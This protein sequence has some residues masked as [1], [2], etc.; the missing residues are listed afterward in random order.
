MDKQFELACSV[1]NQMYDAPM[2]FASNKE[3]FAFQILMIF[4]MCN[5]QLSPDQNNNFFIASG[6]K[7]GNQL[8]NTSD[9]FK[10]EWAKQLITYSKKLLREYDW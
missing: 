9:S 4:T 2:S 3:S 5:I 8:I 7:K 6:M 1:L 10:D